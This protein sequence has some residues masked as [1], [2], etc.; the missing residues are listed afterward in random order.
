M[1]SIDCVF[2]EMGWEECSNQ[3]AS[4]GNNMAIQIA[5]FLSSAGCLQA[6]SQGMYADITALH[7]L[8]WSL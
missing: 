5:A 7:Y 8:L 4:L 6:L 3:V 2:V 1:E